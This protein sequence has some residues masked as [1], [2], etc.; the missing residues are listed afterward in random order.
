[1]KTTGHVK[2]IYDR[3]AQHRQDKNRKIMKRTD[4][5]GNIT[6]EIYN[7]DSDELL[8]KNHKGGKLLLHIKDSYIYRSKPFIDTINLNKIISNKNG[9]IESVPFILFDMKGNKK[10]LFKIKVKKDKN[11]HLNTSNS[12]SRM[13]I[14]GD[15]SKDII[16][17]S[18]QDD[19]I[20]GDGGD[21][22]ISGG[23]GRDVIEAGTGDDYISGGEGN[24]TLRGEQGNDII[25]G[26]DGADSILGGAGIDLLQGGN[27]K[28]YIEGNAGNDYISGDADDD[29]LFGGEGDDLIFGGDGNDLIEGDGESYH[30][31]PAHKNNTGNDH[32]FGGKGDDVII[33]GKGNDFL[34]GGEGDDSYYF[35]SY[36]GANIINE[37]S[38]NN[39]T[40]RFNDHLLPELK[41]ARHGSHLL[42]T[43]KKKGDNLRVLVKDQLSENGPKIEWLVTKS[44]MSETE[45]EFN[46]KIP[47]IFGERSPDLGDITDPD[48]ADMLKN[49]RTYGINKVSSIYHFT[50]PD[51]HSGD[52]LAMLIETMSAQKE[53]A[54]VGISYHDDL[55][56]NAVN[57]LA[58]LLKQ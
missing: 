29:F 57:Y 24:D 20:Y 38:E 22:H 37:T 52:N 4:E 14:S 33:A 56:K 46:I 28:D 44:V 48:I 21:D 19:I 58:S 23:M 8:I 54:L 2:T 31:S 50:Q 42:I 13:L 30:P 3:S 6:L 39:N 35:S 15:R 9:N 11:K 45:S 34:D 18:N 47:D 49:E 53:L 16:S 40:I 12:T 41:I 36:D 51:S 32:L 55:P 25:E 7:I 26:G 27:Q 43:S 1:M 17:G 10:D 5:N